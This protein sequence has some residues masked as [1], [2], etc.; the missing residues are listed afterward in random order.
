[1]SDIKWTDDELAEFDSVTE[2]GSSLRQMDRIEARFE[3]KKL[4]ERHG[5]EKCDAMFAELQKRDKK[6][7]RG[8]T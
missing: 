7:K 5:R 4:I 8:R 2:M 1:M 3:I 6:A